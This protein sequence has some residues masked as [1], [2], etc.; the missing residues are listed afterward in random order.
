MIQSLQAF[1]STLTNAS[2]NADDAPPSLPLAT[3]ALLVE[4]MRADSESS[5][6]EMS[7][8]R[9]VL[10]AEFQLDTNEVD[11]LLDAATAESREAPGFHPFTSRLNQALDAAQKLRVVEYLWA[12]ALADGHVCAHESHLM[13]KLGD[14]LYISRGD[15]VAAKARAQAALG[16]RR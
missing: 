3:A 4:M 12:I 11:Q 14:L 5:P 9:K 8:L 7:H 10:A 6:A 13:R 16:H 1:F 15:L 2:A